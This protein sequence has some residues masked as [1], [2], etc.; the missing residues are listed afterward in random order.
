MPKQL[1]N[2]LTPLAIKHAKPGRI[3]DG[4]GLYLL[5]KPS[6]ARSWI[7]RATVAGKVRDIGLGSATGARA[8]SLSDARVAAREKLREA[9]QGTIPMSDR[10][11]RAHQQA[12]ASQAERLSRAS[13]RTCAEAYIANH[14]DGW[15]N[16]K[17]K[18]QWRSTLEAYAY[19][20]FGDT[21]V[22]SIETEQVLTALQPIWK[23]R[24]ETASRVRGRIE[25]IL[26]AAKVQGLRSGENPARWRGHL[27]H[28][29]QKRSKL[30]RGHHAAIPYADV[31]KFV[32]ELAD[33]EAVSAR[34]L[35]FTILTAARTGET[36][37]ATWGEID[38]EAAV[39]TVPGKRMKAGREHRVP[40]SPRVASILEAI[41]PLNSSGEAGAYLFPAARG[42]TLSNMAMSMLMRRLGSEATVH[43]FRSSFRDWAAESTGY[44]RE[45]CEMALA[46]T[47][48]DKVE[49]AYRRGDLFE[50]RRKLMEALASFCQQNGAAAGQVTPIRRG[51][52]CLS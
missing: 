28:V 4:G 46:H 29:L 5:T 17:H 21:P 34:A 3:A 12:A 51:V 20:L 16:D 7:F 47:I 14:E 52:A 42:G 6:G 11:K 19:P 37:G 40:L 27:D 9:M 44:A 30:A 25:A 23:T 43:G 18:A 50:K 1:F 2:A 45:V 13:F 49:A 31:P 8:I 39:W 22:A 10:R 36:I 38:L 24:P 48:G 32:A 33:R 26:D 15:R 41:K 35:E